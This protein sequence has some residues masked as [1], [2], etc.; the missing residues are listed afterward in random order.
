MRLGLLCTK[1]S[2]PDGRDLSTATESRSFEIFL[3][4]SY[5]PCCF[6]PAVLIRSARFEGS[7]RD[8][9]TFF[10]KRQ[11]RHENCISDR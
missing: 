6:Y 1:V 4:G 5:T 10:Y 7:E 11:G 9:F 8:G 3:L 2:Q